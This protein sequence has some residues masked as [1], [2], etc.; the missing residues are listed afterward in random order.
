MGKRKVAYSAPII[1]GGR[2]VLRD[3]LGDFTVGSATDAERLARQL[4]TIA[5]KAKRI[6]TKRPRKARR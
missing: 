3:P 4:L 1:E 6:T 2:I 5:R